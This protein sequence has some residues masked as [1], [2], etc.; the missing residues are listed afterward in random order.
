[1]LCTDHWFNLLSHVQATPRDPHGLPEV[2]AVWLSVEPVVP[3]TL[4]AA[5]DSATQTALIE[6]SGVIQLASDAFSGV[7]STGNVRTSLQHIGTVFHT[8][9]ILVLHVITHRYK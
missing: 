6:P 8:L 1:M 4:P 5:V 2:F 3:L 9:S 7:E